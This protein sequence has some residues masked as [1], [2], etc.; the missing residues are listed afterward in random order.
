[1]GGYAASDLRTVK[2]MGYCFPRDEPLKIFTFFLFLYLS[3]D[4][5][6]PKSFI[7]RSAFILCLALIVAAAAFLGMKFF[8]QSS[9]NKQAKA[10]IGG[11]FNLVD[12][13]GKDVSEQD[14]QGKYM[15]IYFG[16]TYCPDV[17]PTSLTLLSEAMDIVEAKDPALCQACHTCVHHR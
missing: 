3:L 4:P 13:N 10:L 8:D 9:S 12:H 5:L 1:M 7:A 2:G 16:Y 15:L 17:C 11:P 6:M 14:F